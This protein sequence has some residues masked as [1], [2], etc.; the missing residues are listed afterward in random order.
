MFVRPTQLADELAVSL[1]TIR[2]WIRNGVLPS[3]QRLGP[4][5][6]GWQRETINEWLESRPLVQPLPPTDIASLPGPGGITEL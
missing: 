5:A 1:S 2:N 3:P 4:K 6:I